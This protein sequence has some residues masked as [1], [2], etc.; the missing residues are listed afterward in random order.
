MR[1]FYSLSLQKLAAGRW[2]DFPPEKF[3]F[4]I[5]PKTNAVSL[6][7]FTIKIYSWA[8]FKGNWFSDPKRSGPVLE[9]LSLKFLKELILAGQVSQVFN[10]TI[11]LQSQKTRN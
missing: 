11:F 5:F 6:N 9:R 8:K 1:Y 4:E 10:V 2:S 7:Y 3:Y